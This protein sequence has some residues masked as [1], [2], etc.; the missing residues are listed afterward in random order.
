MKELIKNIELDKIYF[1]CD[2]FEQI[3]NHMIKHPNYLEKTQNGINGYVY[4]INKTWGK[5]NKCFFIIDNDL[6]LIPI[7]YNYGLVKDL[8]KQESLKAFRTCIDM[9]I[10][11]FKKQFIKNVTRCEITNEVIGRIENCHVDHFNFDFIEVVEMFL[12]K[13]NKT[14]SDIYE[15]VEIIDTKRFFKNKHLI[16]YFIKFHNDNTHLRFTTASANLKRKK[17]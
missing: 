9:E 13:Y 15:H 2:F 16:E 17:K 11:K 1:G 5:N 7:S 3:N 14:Y 4:K 8:K 10:F 12:K 6:N